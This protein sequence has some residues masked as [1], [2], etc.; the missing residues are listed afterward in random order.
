M[1]EAAEKAKSAAATS[2]KVVKDVASACEAHLEELRRHAVDVDA[3]A[4]RIDNV[5]SSVD[6]V[7]GHTQGISNARQ[8]I[9]N[10]TDDVSTLQISLNALYTPQPDNCGSQYAF[11]GVDDC[12]SQ[13]ARQHGNCRSDQ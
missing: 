4:S 2:Q 8:S 11:V 6:A 3:L 10:L 9:N 1:D 5:V 7:A 12:C 13:P